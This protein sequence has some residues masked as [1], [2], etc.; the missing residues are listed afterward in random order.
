[1]KRRNFLMS[2]IAGLLAFFGVKPKADGGLRIPAGFLK[3]GSIVTCTDGRITKLTNCIFVGHEECQKA[4]RICDHFERC[5][6]EGFEGWAAVYE[7]GDT[8]PL[9]LMSLCGVGVK[10][11][12]ITII[13]CAF[14]ER[15]RSSPLT[16]MFVKALQEK[17]V[18]YFSSILTV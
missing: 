6:F 11:R 4:I 1:M 7:A 17:N 3:V 15:G 14:H 16:P 13:N 2:G 5:V 10:D 18:N 12:K 8:Y 9:R